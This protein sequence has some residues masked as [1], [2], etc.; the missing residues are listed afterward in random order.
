MQNGIA[1]LGILFHV[2]VEP[3]PIIEKILQ[4]AGNVFE[5]VNKNQTLQEKMLLSELFQNNKSSFFRYEGS[6]TTPNCGESV[7]WTV[8]ESS[9]PISLDQVQI[10]YFIILI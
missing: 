5:A 6:L 9:V 4:N 7:M 8:F 1:V 3:N 10:S 2:A